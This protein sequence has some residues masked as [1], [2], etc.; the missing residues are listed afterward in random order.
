MGARLV[1][2]LGL[3]GALGCGATRPATSGPDVKAPAEVELDA[4]QIERLLPAKA[5]P[6]SVWA[7]A[8]W[9]GLLANSVIP[10][11]TSACAVIA[12]VAQESGFQAD[13]VVPGLAKLVKARLD[14]YRDKLPLLGKPLFARLLSGRSPEDARSFEARLDT[15]RTEGDLDR[16]FRD[17]LRYYKANHPTTFAA[18]NFAGKLFDVENLAAL[19]PITT[20]GSMQVNVRFAEEWAR[21]AKGADPDDVREQLYTIKG[22]VFYGTA[23]LMGFEAGYD[24]PV[25]RFADY[26]AGVYASRNAAVQAQVGTLLGLKLAW[27]GDLLSY[28]PDGTPKP[29]ETETM[30]ALEAFALK[31]APKL[32]SCSLREDALK[33]KTKKFENTK[34]WAELKRAFA[35]KLGRPPKYAI[36]PDVAIS[37][38]KFTQTRST[39]WFAQSVD[40]RYRTCL[41]AKPL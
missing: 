25:Y 5:K 27:D 22:G 20:A 31:Y 9:N 17:M 1:V 4:R 28:E 26:N 15:V 13:P 11:Q 33:E 16:V 7:E 6:A 14:G 19:N 21:D 29:D 38:P 30:R 39:A 24:D 10:T 37:S 35:A 34:T 40:R 12:V 8:V 3:L 2:V 41:D 23:R 36:L 18:A 32:S